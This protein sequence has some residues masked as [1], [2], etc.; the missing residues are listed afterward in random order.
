MRV[1]RSSAAL[2]LAV[3]LAATPSAWARSPAATED[4]NPEAATGSQARELARAAHFMVVAAN[5]WRPPPA[6]KCSSA[7]AAWWMPPSP[8]SWC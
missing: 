8:R 4:R 6:T 5:P 7:A 1:R 2:L 3:M